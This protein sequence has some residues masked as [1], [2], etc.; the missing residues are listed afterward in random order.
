MYKDELLK[1]LYDSDSMELHPIE[2][3]ILAVIAYHSEAQDVPIPIS[4]MKIANCSKLSTSTILRHMS[5]L[6][7]KRFLIK[8]KE[9]TQTLPAQYLINEERLLG[10]RAHYKYKEP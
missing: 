5:Q 2:V 9:H 3:N 7:K 8:T 6:I 4:V 10:I 1:I